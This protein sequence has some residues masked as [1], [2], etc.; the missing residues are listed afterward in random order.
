MNNEIVRTFHARVL[1]VD[2]ARST[3]DNAKV[4]EA[5]VLVSVFDIEDTYPAIGNDDVQIIDRGAFAE[6]V[7]A[8]PT[9]KFFLNHGDF[10][11]LGY[12]DVR[13]QIGKAVN[14]RETDQGLVFH[15]MWNLEVQAARESFS[16]ILFGPELAEF[17]FRNPISSETHAR[18]ADGRDHVQAIR[19]VSEV[20]HVGYGAQSE[21]RVLAE[22][23]AARAKEDPNAREWLVEMVEEVLARSAISS[24]HT[25]TV[26]TAWSGSAAWRGCPSVA[27]ALKKA[28]AWRDPDGD[29]DVKATYKFIHHMVSDGKVGA[30]NTRA[31]T[32]VIGNLNGARSP[33][34]IP[35]ADKAGVYRHVATHLKD[36]GKTPAPLRSGEEIDASLRE[37]EA[38]PPP[39]D[40]TPAGEPESSEETPAAEGEGE[41][42]GTANVE[43]V[44]DSATLADFLA[45]S[46]EVVGELHANPELRGSLRDMLAEAEKPDPVADFLTEAWSTLK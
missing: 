26:D 36:A 1:D 23:L 15:G 46:P 35:E 21:T 33:A 12:T 37:G 25:S 41:V 5:D 18:G 27:A 40:P 10:V 2:R 17:S 7:A 43:I 11:N 24:H 4:G 42:V 34:D 3:F 32:S 44:A 13:L 14:F 28:T 16:N 22:T 9:R 6:F 20:S 30:A 31:C 45:K 29:P 8:N 19:E 39:E 38:T